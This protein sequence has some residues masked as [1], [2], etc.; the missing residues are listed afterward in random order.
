VDSLD[1]STP[2]GVSTDD[3]TTMQFQDASTVVEQKSELHFDTMYEAVNPY[4]DSVAREIVERTVQLPATTWTS[5]SSILFFAD[6]ITSMISSSQVIKNVW[7]TLS[8]TS[9]GFGMFRFM[10]CGFKFIVKVNSTQYHQ[11]TLVAGWLPDLL[12]HEQL[13]VQNCFAHNAIVLSASTQDQATLEAPYYGRKPHYDL[14]YG[15]PESQPIFFLRVLNPLVTSNPSVADTVEVSLFLQA[16]NVKMYALLPQ[17]PFPPL[18]KSLWRPNKGLHKGALFEKIV[19]KDLE[20]EKRYRVP[21]METQSGQNKKRP[22]REVHTKD[23][24]GLSVPGVASLISPIIRSIPYAS[25]VIDIG[26]M[27]LSNLDKPTTDQS[28]MYIREEGNRGHNWLTGVDYCEELSSFPSSS[29]AR[30]LGME[31]SDINVVDY[32]KKPLLFYSEVITTAGVKFYIPVHPMNFLSSIRTEPDFLAFGTSFYS[33][34]RGSIKF[35]FQF[36]GTP[37]YS[38]RFKISVSHTGAAVAGGTGDGT[39]YYSHIVD[40]KGDAWFELSVPFLCARTWSST[41]DWTG[42]DDT[43]LTV[44]ALTDVQGS[45]LPAT[46]SYYMNIY[47]AAG[48]DYQLASLQTARNLGLTPLDRPRLDNNKYTRQYATVIPGMEAQCS[49]AGRFKQPFQGITPTATG[50]LETGINM[51][52]TSSTVSDV[53]K[54]FSI[55]TFTA[56]NWGSYPNGNGPLEPASAPGMIFMWSRVYAFWRGSRRIKRIA[57]DNN[58]QLLLRGLWGDGSEHHYDGTPIN[59]AASDYVSSCTV[60]W[61]C[62][63]S[64]SPAAGVLTYTNSPEDPETVNY[65]DYVY[66]SDSRLLLAAGDDFCFLYPIAPVVLAHMAEERKSAKSKD[67]PNHSN[68]E[69][70]AGRGMVK[71]KVPTA[72]NVPTPN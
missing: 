23:E 27:I 18:G 36:V 49:V 71:P 11:G 19:Q 15:V 67:V 4:T 30:T 40:A 54:R 12:D 43:F 10:R 8:G 39:G 58:S 47:R 46:A 33:Y 24:Q 45:S 2:Q 13:D 32:C 37:F 61:Y 41:F 48:D 20:K 66:P 60:P 42:N 21:G 59:L 7:G 6:P 26:K 56:R 63:N 3:T 68:V 14:A 44:E 17:K 51:A 57:S 62:L 64:W 38:C 31:S 16:T 53:C 5:G 9:T 29:V 69:N 65:Y 34:W 70:G 35:L 72:S 28:I 1:P 50:T 55:Y 25:D 52:D 22:K